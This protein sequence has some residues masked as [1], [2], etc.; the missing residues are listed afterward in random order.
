MAKN[1][2][3]KVILS[4]IDR[5]SGPVMHAASNIRKLGTAASGWRARITALG[6][7]MGVPVF[8]AAMGEAGRRL[9]DFREAAGAAWGVVQR[10]GVAVGIAGA[11]ALYATNAYADYTGTINDQMKATGL[12]AE[13]LQGWAY[14]AKQNGIE[15]E[16]FFAA[17]RIGSK[18]IGLAAVGQGKAVQVLQAFGIGLKDN[19][20]KLRTMDALLP[21]IADKIAAL[22]SPQLQAAAASQ[23]FGKS[24]MDMLP[25]LTQGSAGIKAMTD[26]A[27]ELG[28]VLD[29]DAIKA[30]DDLGDTMDELRGAMLGVRNTAFKE[31]APTLI[32][33]AR[34]VTDLIVRNRPEITA[35]ARA[36]AE[37]LPTAIDKA[38]ASFAALY[39]IIS[40][41]ISVLGFLNDLFG[42]QNLIL[43]AL[44]IT[45][46]V[47]VTTAIMAL[48]PVV[49]AL[50]IALMTTPVGWII[51]GLTA[52]ALA[53]LAIYKNWDTL[54]AWW[55]GVW[56]SIGGAVHAAV[57]GIRGMWDGL[58]SWLIGKITSG[59]Q[60]ITGIMP[61]WLVDMLGGN[62][63]VQVNAQQ[64]TMS[65]AELG[66]QAARGA[67]ENVRVTVDLNNL[68]AGS[69][70][71]T[72]NSGAQFDLNQGYVLA[73]P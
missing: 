45:I 53:A 8:T 65:A 43:G 62:S 73:A 70:V 21:E 18:T 33:L 41:F 66:R 46:A 10:L 31:L 7:S 26:R 71:A 42:L 12:S 27:R 58:W 50:G 68:P 34:T 14:A 72:E 35:F 54:V 15:A 32:V 23:L 16:K 28:L 9:G 56:S 13:A 59:I 30:G 49:K 63:T 57:E 67:Q 17:M 3:I 48:I 20:G 36:F 22:K 5:I 38:G 44:G 25:F 37:K 60:R 19:T 4:A 40:P 11:A 6:G 29:G 64:P 61:G 69:R 51:A 1:F 52:V 39:A 24:G 55:K 2:P 47:K